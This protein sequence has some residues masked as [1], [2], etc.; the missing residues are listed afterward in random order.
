M[1]TFIVLVA[2]FFSVVSCSSQI[3]LDPSTLESAITNKEFNY[4][5]TR[6]FPMNGDVINVLNSLPNTSSSRILN[7][8]PGYGFNLKKDI[9]SVGLPYFGRAY[10]A[11]P[12]DANNGG[13]RFESKVFD[14]KKSSTKKG[15]TLLIIT[16]RDTKENYVFN[17][18]I[19]KNGSAFL[20]V[21]S[22]NRQ[23]ISFDGN[24]SVDQ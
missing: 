15:N 7:L 5:A 18:E 9:L 11:V 22:N 23:P 8:D 19:F 4:N 6:A 2:A 16:P 17:L 21:Q 24:I 13:V 1:R 12:G 20:S 10:N 14:I 3:Y